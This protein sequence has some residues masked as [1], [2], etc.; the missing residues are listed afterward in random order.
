MTVC[1][2]CGKQFQASQPARFCSVRC[3]VA[4]HRKSKRPSTP[5]RYTG[6]T[7]SD[8]AAYDA[9]VTEG[10]AAVAQGQAQEIA[11]LRAR[12]AELEAELED[13]FERAQ[14]ELQDAYEMG[15]EYGKGWRDGWDAAFD[16]TCDIG[17]AGKALPPVRQLPPFEPQPL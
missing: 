10:R 1:Q 13:A 16:I 12:V 6:V 11:A 8:Q 9:L 2:H 3:R 15:I 17:R 14:A 4:A 7:P 5:R